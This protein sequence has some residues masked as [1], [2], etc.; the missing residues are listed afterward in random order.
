MNVKCA[1]VRLRN[2]YRR[3]LSNIP[4]KG[5]FFLRFKEGPSLRWEKCIELIKIW[6]IRSIGEC[7][8]CHEDA[9]GTTASAWKTVPRN[10][11]EESITQ[12]E[13]LFAEAIGSDLLLPEAAGGR[14]DVCVYQS[15]RCLCASVCAS[16]SGFFSER[17]I[18]QPTTTRLIE[19]QASAS[20]VPTQGSS[21]RRCFPF[22]RA[23]A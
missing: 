20:L 11:A 4:L 1:A 14:V 16:V 23:T 6:L 3:Y 15:A 12:L 19:A 21:W 13:I 7:S 8:K 2:R 18:F 10:R 5:W 17:L 22:Q 9:D